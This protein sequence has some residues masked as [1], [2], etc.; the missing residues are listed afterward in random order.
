MTT[1]DSPHRAE[2]WTS[3]VRQ[4]LGLGRLLPLGGPADG[5]W[6]AERAAATVL[7][8]ATT[9][10]GAVLGTLRIAPADEDDAPDPVV[11]RPPSALRPGPLRIEAGFATTA[12]RPLHTTADA[13][14]AALLTA[15]AQRLGLL[16]DEV[17]LRVTELL[18]EEP[19]PAPEPPADVIAAEPAG[20]DPAGTA[21]AGVPGVVALTRV[22]GSAVQHT[23]GHVRVEL[24]T[25]GDHRAL[26]VAQAVRGAVAD[27]VEG[28][29]TV[30]VLVTAVVNRN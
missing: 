27:A 24:A 6:I 19:R 8:E 17:D 16:V 18:E 4:R 9:G 20:S 5:S 7:R 2:G 10:T 11:P 30:A 1:A 13:L 14:R 26:D 22:L 21:A 12:R 23:E 15:A 29:P 25:A 3:A 28:R